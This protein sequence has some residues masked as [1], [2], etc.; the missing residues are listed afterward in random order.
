MPA[1]GE[2]MGKGPFCTYLLAVSTRHDIVVIFLAWHYMSI[3]VTCHLHGS[4]NG[5]WSG[6]APICGGI[7]CII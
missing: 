7:L 1:D 2:W 5:Q 4:Y 3:N 6:A